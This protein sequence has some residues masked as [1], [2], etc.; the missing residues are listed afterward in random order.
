[1]G[2]M[3]ILQGNR[4]EGRKEVREGDIKEVLIKLCRTV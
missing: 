2:E 1:V 3:Q 4:R